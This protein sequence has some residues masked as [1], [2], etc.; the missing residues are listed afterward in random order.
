MKILFA[1]P[2]RDLLECYKKLLAPDLGEIVTS[3]DG[4]HVLSLLSSEQFDI[5]VLD[6]T[7][8]RIEFG[9]IVALMRETNLPVVGLINGPVSV[10]RL[11]GK[12]IANEYLS[13]PFT[14]KDMM[15]KIND[16]AKKAESDEKMY[17]SGLEIDVGDFRIKD[18]SFLTASEIDVLMSLINGY[19]VSESEGAYVS[20]LNAKLSK[21]GSKTA[22]KYRTKKG[23]ELVNTDE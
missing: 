9:T 19:P 13:Y 17:V 3:F 6:E 15:K 4:T 20:A 14:T 1:A 12:S 10:S 11:T 22:I 23:F 7:I 5:A 8:P 21:A 2:D 16:V 18:G